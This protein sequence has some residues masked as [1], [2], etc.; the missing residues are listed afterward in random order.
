MAG[1]YLQIFLFIAFL[2]IG[3]VVLFHLVPPFNYKK[4]PALDRR[5]P[6]LKLTC[7]LKLLSVRSMM[8]SAALFSYTLYVSRYLPAS[9]A[10]QPHETPSSKQKK[11]QQQEQTQKNKQDLQ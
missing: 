8:A 4:N 5:T 10:L 7:T 9:S 1:K 2:L 11:Q 3:P 6:K